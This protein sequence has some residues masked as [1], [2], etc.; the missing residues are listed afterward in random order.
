MLFRSTLQNTQCAVGFSSISVS[1][2]TATL[3]A[4]LVFKTPAF[5]GSK[6]VYLQGTNPWGSS[7]LTAKGTWTVP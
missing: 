6:S 2:G 4:I 1:S 3:S 7:A 5:S